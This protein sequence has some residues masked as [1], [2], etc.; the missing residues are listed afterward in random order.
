[1]NHYCKGN[2]V[3]CK[4]DIDLAYTFCLE[5]ELYPFRSTILKEASSTAQAQKADCVYLHGISDHIGIERIA[6]ASSKIDAF[7]KMVERE[8]NG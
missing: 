3:K 5:N 8:W 7:S 6:K 1:M 2:H 4:K